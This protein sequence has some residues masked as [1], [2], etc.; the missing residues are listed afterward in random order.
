M[1]ALP[2][3]ENQK[4]CLDLVKSDTNNLKSSIYG[5]SAKCTLDRWFGSDMVDASGYEMPRRLDWSLFKHIYDI[6]PSNYE[7]LLSI[8]GLGGVTV[9][10]LSLIAE[11]IYGA[12][13]SCNDPVKYSFAYGGK[14][15]E[16]YT[17]AK[18]VYDKSVRIIY[19]A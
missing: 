10:A 4:V 5:L 3:E 11:L 15:G 17:V 19:G 6:Q 7:E 8:R 16:P 1:T 9:R 12:K 18:N 14:D 2:S 13:A